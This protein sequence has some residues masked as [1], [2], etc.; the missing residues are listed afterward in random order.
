MIGRERPIVDHAHDAAAVRRPAFD[1]AEQLLGQRRHPENEDAL[2]PRKC[3]GKRYACKGCRRR[4]HWR[5]LLVCETRRLLETPGL[6][7]MQCRA[8]PRFAARERDGQFHREALIGNRFARAGQGSIL[9][10]DSSPRH[11]RQPACRLDDGL[12]RPACR[13][14]RAGR[15]RALRVNAGVAVTVRW[16]IGRNAPVAATRWTSMVP[17][18]PNA[19]S[20]VREYA[21]ERSP[22]RSCRRSTADTSGRIV[23]SVT[24]GPS[25]DLET[26]SWRDPVAPPGR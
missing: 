21:S 18:S 22:R 25:G 17:R 4:N 19:V 10:A 16:R 1:F 14:E 6:S 2:G 15:P 3:R 23:P 7:G 5:S 8:A 13:P 24:R 26:R 20:S 11:H 12:R 9:P